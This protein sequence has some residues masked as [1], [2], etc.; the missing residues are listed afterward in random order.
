[1]TT[2]DY[3][4]DSLIAALSKARIPSDNHNYIQRLMGAVGIRE[5]RAVP[6]S[7]KPYVVAVRHDGLP[8]LR[9]F[10][11][12]TIGF[13]NGDEAQRV[14]FGSDTIRASDDAGRVWLVSH[15]V[16]GDLEKRGPSDQMKKRDPGMCP[17]CGIYEMS[18]SGKCQSCD[19][20]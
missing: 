16:H 2:S 14:G 9:I 18:V 11:G 4:S 5:Y 6:K 12:Y 20:D 19:E 1:M 8:D 10:S 17:R 7:D 15:P 13:T 3:S